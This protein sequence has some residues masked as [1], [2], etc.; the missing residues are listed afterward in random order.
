MERELPSWPDGT[1]LERQEIRHN[2]EQCGS[3]NRVG[4]YEVLSYD[5]C[6]DRGSNTAA[7]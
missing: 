1:S 3:G 6:H 2:R 4:R 5:K 7:G